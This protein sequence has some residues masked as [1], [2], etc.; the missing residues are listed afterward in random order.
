[1][2]L[3]EFALDD[4]VAVITLNR[5]EARNAINP[6]VGVRLAGRTRHPPHQPMSRQ[7]MSRQRMP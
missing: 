1:M 4:H 6:E 7:P 2:A 5:P 3:V